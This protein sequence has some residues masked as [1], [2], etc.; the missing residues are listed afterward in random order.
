MSRTSAIGAIP[1]KATNDQLVAFSPARPARQWAKTYFS[2]AMRVVQGICRAEKRDA[3]KELRFA[4]GH[5]IRNCERFV[6][7]TRVGGFDTAINL[8]FS[9]NGVAFIDAFAEERRKAGL[10][11]P[12]WVRD[13]RAM[14]AAA[15]IMREQVQID[16]QLAR[17]AK[18][19][20]DL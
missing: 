20:K 19:L 6:A 18:R 10:P 7:Q 8:I 4:T 16:D 12:A 2:A 14:T 3:A 9:D 17:G 15:K 13:L 5:S 11:V 1:Q